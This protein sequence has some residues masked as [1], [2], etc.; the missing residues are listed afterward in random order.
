M[1]SRIW[2][3][4]LGGLSTICWL[5]LEVSQELRTSDVAEAPEE[6]HLL[7]PLGSP[8]RD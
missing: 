1:Q 8:G 3:K 5:L 6:D 4:T 2:E 7:P